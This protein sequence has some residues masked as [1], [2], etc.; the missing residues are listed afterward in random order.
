[1]YDIKLKK[2]RKEIIDLEQR[3]HSVGKIIKSS[4]NEEIKPELEIKKTELAQELNT[5][6]L[7]YKDLRKANNQLKGNYKSYSNKIAAQTT[8][9]IKK[10]NEISKVDSIAISKVSGGAPGLGKKS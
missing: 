1:M 8:Q 4:P 7:S 10:T 5:L 9:K 6:Q 3:I 2:L